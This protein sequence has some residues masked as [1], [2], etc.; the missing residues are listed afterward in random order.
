MSYFILFAIIS[1]VL[2]IQFGGLGKFE[3]PKTS[4]LPH[5]EARHYEAAPSLFVNKA[6]RAFFIIL[7]QTLGSDYLLMSK[8]RLEDVIGV[9]RT[10]KDQKL[11]WSLRGRVKSRHIDFLICAR[12]G[13]PLIGIELDGSVHGG[14]D[15]HNADELKNEIF[16]SA[17]LDFVRVSTAEDFDTA[18]NRIKQRL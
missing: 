2:W 6:E 11:R 5:G 14:R 13:R 16:E 7:S 9:K 4:R 15:A 10:V 12:D 18:A 3:P 1:V 17:G 8:T